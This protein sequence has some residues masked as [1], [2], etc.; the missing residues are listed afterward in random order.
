ML[1]S[2]PPETVLKIF[3]Y[4]YITDIHGL[5]LLSKFWDLFI[6]KH[7][8]TIYRECALIH[9]F[10]Q[11]GIPLCDA[12]GSDH[13]AWLDDLDSWKDLCQRWFRLEQ[14]WEGIGREI[15]QPP[16]EKHMGH[17]TF[18][19]H[20][21]KVDEK[22]G[23]I[24]S[25]HRMGGLVVS[26]IDH[27]GVLFKLSSNYVRR[28]SHIEY[29]NGYMVFDRDEPQSLEVWRLQTPTWD[30]TEIPSDPPNRCRPHPTQLH[31]SSQEVEC[32][33]PSGQGCFSP[34]AHLHV[35]LPSGFCAYRFV[36]PTLLVASNVDHSVYLFDI[37]S[38]TLVQ[39]ISLNEHRF[40]AEH[41]AFVTYVEL[42]QRHIFVCTTHGIL[43]V[44]RS[45]PTIN[46]VVIFPGNSI[47][48]HSKALQVTYSPLNGGHKP[49][50]F[51]GLID[52][53]SL[54]R[55]NPLNSRQTFAALHVSPDGKNFAASTWHGRVFLVKDFE[56][57]IRGECAFSEVTVQIQLDGPAKSLAFEYGRVAVTSTL[58]VHIINWDSSYHGIVRSPWS[59][60]R[61]PLLPHLT[62]HKLG[63]LTHMR[64]FDE[65][66]VLQMTKTA[67]WMSWEPVDHEEDDDDDLDDNA[68]AQPVVCAIDFRPR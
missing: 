21:I 17:A 44:L 61:P 31:A 25:T 55:S 68:R 3:S 52:E 57:V 65:V 59:S 33:D 49:G 66:N 56:R 48:T 60:Y 51:R 28:R 63:R 16:I 27:G 45:N 39:S 32:R 29:A 8:S 35:P 62:I 38:A 18:G 7:E 23:F 50:L 36:Y 34:W 1:S 2:L 11:P 42:G 53:P 67:V 10:A 15:H 12:R 41:D 40:F 14:N 30:G 43:I 20:G 22:H 46:E 64:I 26:S 54:S 5:Q 24:I 37:P 6:R 13:G 9:R 19:A 4:V 58:G 47:P